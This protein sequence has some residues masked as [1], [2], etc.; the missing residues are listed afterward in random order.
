MKRI[1]A[2]VVLI[3]LVTP[4]LALGQATP[5]KA[6]LSKTSSIEQE[7]I[8]L[9]DGWSA[10]FVS[11]DVAFCDRILAE[12]YTDT[13][14]S[15]TVT[16]KAQDIADLKSGDFKCTSAAN[17][18]YKVRVYGKTAV[19]TGRLTMKAQY[20]GEDISGQY[21]WTDTW[22]K[23]AGGWQCV[24]THVSKIVEEKQAPS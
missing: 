23:L 2:G 5:Q 12:D 18:D 9:E 1:L 20:K 13:D 4:W 15:G 10:A 6:G 17:D 11:A 22:V 14:A 8:K 21:R 3:G 7:L 19:V 24:A 16:T